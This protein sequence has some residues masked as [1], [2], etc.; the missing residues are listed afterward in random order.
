[1]KKCPFCAEE[2]RDDAIKCRYCGEFFDAPP[3]PRSE[4][5]PTPAERRKAEEIRRL[6][7]IASGQPT[8]AD[9]LTKTKGLLA[10]GIIVAILFYTYTWNKK[11]AQ[12]AQSEHVQSKMTFE[13]INALFG[14]ASPL[15]QNLKQTLFDRHRGMNVTWTGTVT[16]I[17]TGQ[18]EDLFITVQH[19]MAMPT[20]GVQ[21][22]FREN[23][24][25]QLADLRTGQSIVY[26]GQLAD[27]DEMAHFF[28]LRDGTAHVI[29]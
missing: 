27:Y 14:P 1:M 18:G 3:T 25:T 12:S 4:T 22:R 7:R 16:Y 6:Q 23:N 11:H 17:N 24:R 2:I 13:E 9:N 10:L 28:L 5:E 20:A 29:E 15:P 8:R 21:V 19:P 26:T